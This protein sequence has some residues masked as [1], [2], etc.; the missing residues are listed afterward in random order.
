VVGQGFVGGAVVSGLVGGAV[1]EG[2]GYET[3]GTKN[4]VFFLPMDGVTYTVERQT[5]T[6][7]PK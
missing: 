2:Q 4:V 3:T 5:K 7:V 1:R 6:Y